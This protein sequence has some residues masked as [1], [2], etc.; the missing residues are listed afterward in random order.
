MRSSAALLLLLPAIAAA[1][2]PQPQDAWSGAKTERVMM[3]YADDVRARKAFDEAHKALQTAAFKTAVRNYEAGKVPELHATWG[4]FVTAQGTE[5]IALQLAPAAP[6][7]AGAKVIAF[8]EIV[9]AAGKTIY[10]FEEPADVADSKGD[11]YIERTL[12]LPAWNIVG[13]FGLAAGGEIVAL[14]RSAMDGESLTKATAGVSRLIV[15]NNVYNLTRLQSPFDP[16]AFGGTKVVPKPDRTFKKSDEV[17]LFTELRNPGIDAQQTPH[18]M[19]KVE[20][21]GNGKRVAMPQQAAD[22]SPLKGVRGH[23]GVG[24]TV[25]LSRLKPGDYKVRL[26]LNDTI[27]NQT[28]QREETIHLLD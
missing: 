7:K 4:E 26:T 8:G 3:R 19:M 20:L 21:E 2:T 5:Y 1:Q 6:L 14:T 17:W 11:P 12:I 25:D 15:S 13:T 23:Y 27:A 24:T 18:V 16:F 9:D 10:D 22:A 28:Y